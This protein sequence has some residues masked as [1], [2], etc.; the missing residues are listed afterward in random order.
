MKITI[1]PFDTASIAKAIKELE[2]YKKEF[3]AKEAVFVKRL[4][5]IG[6]SV[7]STGFSTADYDGVNDVQVTMTQSG[8]S[9]AVIAF[10]DT[11]GFIEFGTGVRFPEWDNSGMEYT[12]PKH[13][14]YGKGLGARPKGWYFTVGEGAS[15]HTYGN[16]PAEAMRTARDV[17]IEKVT[18]I[19]REV[20]R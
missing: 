14:T 12:P 6:V 1:N 4:A 3:L 13:G 11:V 8:T 2:Q 9:A 15:R 5:E 17:M 16:P 20:W 18:Q 10:G 7:A 19:A